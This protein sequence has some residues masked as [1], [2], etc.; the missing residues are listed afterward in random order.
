MQ[1]PLFSCSVQDSAL[2][3]LQQRVQRLHHSSCQASN[4]GRN[5]GVS[6]AVKETGRVGDRRLMGWRRRLAQS[7]E[8]FWMWAPMSHHSSPCL[9]NS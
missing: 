2:Q 5:A 6:A 9:C 3:P 4:P 1:R 8:R 7:G